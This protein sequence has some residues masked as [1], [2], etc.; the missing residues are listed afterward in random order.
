[1]NKNKQMSAVVVEEFGNYHNL[2]YKEVTEPEIDRNQVKIKMEDVGV[3]PNES[4][5]LTGNYNLFIPELPFTPGFDGAGVIEEIGDDVSNF[6]VGDRVFVG[7]FRKVNQSGTYAEKVVVDSDI[8]L[9]L[10]DNA[11]FEQGAAL[12]IPGF[13]AYH[14]LFQR[15]NLKAGETVFIHGATGGVGTLAVQMAKSIGATVIGTSSTEEGLQAILDNGADYAMNHLN[16]NNFDQLN[17]YTNG[18]GPDVIIEFLANKNLELDLQAIKT[19]GR[20]V[21]VGARDTI[22]ISPRLILSRNINVLGASLP[23]LTEE[24]YTEASAGII[25]M[26][27]HGV[28]NPIIGESVP[29]REV[30]KVHE[31]LL[32][33]SGNGKSILKP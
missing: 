25:A 7:T 33:R 6:Q 8:V 19:K 29:L 17:E 12:G 24:D 27:E 10:P 15:A 11:S 4:Y 28:I 32:T 2:L 3:N 16:D 18:L 20:I 5:V 1:M 14:I 30:Q 21:V 9:P 23:N 22:E 26:L 31:N 13:T